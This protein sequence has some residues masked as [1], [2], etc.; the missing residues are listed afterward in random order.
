MATEFA[1]ARTRNRFASRTVLE[2]AHGRQSL[3]MAFAMTIIT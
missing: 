1:V 2:Q 3:L